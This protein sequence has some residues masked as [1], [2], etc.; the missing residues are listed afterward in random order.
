[1]QNFSLLLFW[2]FVYNE[3]NF[4]K[5][6]F[7][8]DDYRFH[9]PKELIAET[10]TH[11]AHNARLLVASQSG[12]IVAEATFLDLPRFLSENSVLF[13]NNSRVLRARI[14]L[15]NHKIFHENIEKNISD[16]EI[17]FLKNTEKNHFEALVRPGKKFKIGT[18]IPIGNTILTVTEQTETGRIFH[19]D[20]GDI[21][22][23]LEDFGELPLPP[24][25]EYSP[26][27]ESDYQNTFAA[28]S[29]SV[30]APTAGLH[31]TDEL[32][33]NIQNEKNFITLHIG[34]GTF[35]TIDT[36]DIRQYNI[37]SETAEV[38]MKIFE[39]I[40][41]IKNSGKIVTAVGTT[42]CRT[43]ESLLSLWKKFDEKTKNIFSENVK[44]FWE[45][46][47]ENA[48]EKWIDNFFINGENIEFATRAYITPGYSFAVID[49]LITNFHLPESS[50]LVLV[51]AL[52]G[53]R[54]LMN[55]YSHAISQKYR[56]F[57]L[58][59]GM[60]LKK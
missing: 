11:P 47:S 58:G 50:L 28:K 53:Q 33:E 22:G 48:D 8:L 44:N 3:K 7:S 4:Y 10:A 25:I 21:Y 43:L 55:L 32:L 30:A 27:K 5:I 51:S 38:G 31:F 40:F 16:G 46:I 52:I 14:P 24:Y 29:G 34:L 35:K 13:F 9:L 57:S 41:E 59:D 17:F 15:K 12:A 23:L 6:M 2:I 26:E 20:N 39:K 54:N 19:I 37:H 56:F 49:E 45:K 36:D 18:K 42:A 60:Y 1:M